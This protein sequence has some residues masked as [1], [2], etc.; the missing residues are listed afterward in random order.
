MTQG[1][2]SALIADVAPVSLRASAF[3]VFNFASGV[4]LLLASLI[5]GLLWAHVGPCATFL[6]GATFTVLGLCLLPALRSRQ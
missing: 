5:A 6:A 3:G 1:L 4:A 2:L